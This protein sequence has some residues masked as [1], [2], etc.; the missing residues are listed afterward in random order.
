ML[1]QLAVYLAIAVTAV[2]GFADGP[3][4]ALLARAA[5]VVAGGA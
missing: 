5:A 4:A 3:F 1:P 2:A